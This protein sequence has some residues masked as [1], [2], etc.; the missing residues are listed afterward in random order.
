MR[1]EV[2]TVGTELLLGDT[3]NTNAAWISKRLSEYG[4]TLYQQR[5]VGDNKARLVNVLR[6][7]CMQ[8]DLVITTGG[9]GPT[10]DDITRECVAEALGVELVTD[11]FSLQRIE[12]F[13]TAR[14]RTMSEN[15]RRQAQLPAGGTALENSAGTAP[16]CIITQQETTVVMLPGPPHEMQHVFTAHIVPY[17]ESQSGM[18]LRSRTLRICGIG[19]SDMENRVADIIAQ[20]ENP[21]VAPYAK[22]GECSLRVT[23]YTSTE[24]EAYARIA[25][26]ERELVSRLEPYVYGYDDDTL[27]SRCAALLRQREYTFACAESCT[28]GM[29]SSRLVSLPGISDIYR[30]AVVSY[31]NMAKR[32]VLGVSKETLAVHGAVSAETV[33]EMA[34]GVR[35]TFAADVS[36]AVSGIAGPDGGTEEKPVG[37]V[38][39]AVDIRGQIAVHRMILPGDRER[40]R[41]RAVNT[42]L[43]QLI[44][45]L[46]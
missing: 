41:F 6:D 12:S 22:L 43:Y 36:A 5:T 44:T 8:N 34:S 40:I 9:L 25:P 35:K 38:Y 32:A 11:R 29:L 13:F 27:E 26:V 21:T 45:A 33:R 19:E 23:A 3:V 20:S 39:V 31:S 17:L 1:C 42:I 46:A 24:E 18:V 4:V 2:I 10:Q 37:L 30:G 7:A 28:G 14:N 16:G 15:N